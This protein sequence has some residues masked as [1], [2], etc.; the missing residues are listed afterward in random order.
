MKKLI[1][2]IIASLAAIPVALAHCPLCTA[3]AGAAVVGARAYGVDDAIV[4]VLLGTL[5]VSSS[6]WFNN[7]LV[8]KKG[9]EFIPFQSTS[10]IIAGLV[11]TLASFAI[12]K[13]FADNAMLF[14][15]PR[16]M[17]GMLLGTFTTT[18]GHKIHLSLQAS[19]DGK[20]HIKFQGLAFIIGAAVLTCAALVVGGV[21]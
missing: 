9:R 8:K 20:N 13:L 21:I 15:L 7:W 19:N 18:L 14:G 11:I 2:G 12:G 17:T 4:G 1:S 6:L 5:I 16:L 10:L 3:A